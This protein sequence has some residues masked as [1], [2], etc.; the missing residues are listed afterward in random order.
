[1]CV[2]LQAVSSHVCSYVQSITHV[3]GIVSHPLEASDKLARLCSLERPASMGSGMIRPAMLRA[4]SR[5]NRAKR[6]SFNHKART[7]AA[8][9]SRRL[10]RSIP[11]SELGT[12]MAS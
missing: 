10:Q 7:Q 3:Q 8:N 9:H 1:M 6:H 11:S 2:C 5:I 4:A 12:I